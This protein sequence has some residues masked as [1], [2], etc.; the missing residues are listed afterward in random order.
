ML[1][2]DLKELAERNGWKAEV[3]LDE[4]AWYHARLVVAD[5][6][7][8]VTALDAEEVNVEAAQDALGR[9]VQALREAR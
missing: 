2:A 1:W 7:A 4:N 5:D 6:G 9:A 3:I 8:C